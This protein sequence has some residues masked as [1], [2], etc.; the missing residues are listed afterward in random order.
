MNFESRIDADPF[1]GTNPLL[2]D[3]GQGRSKRRLIIAGVVLLLIMAAI[4][5]MVHRAGAGAGAEADKKDQ[6][7]VVSVIT[8]GRATIEGTISA[9]GT[10]AARRELPVGIAGEG[11]QVV[12][13]LV[14]PGQWVRAGQVMAVIDRSVQVQQ[15]SSQAAQVS[16]ARANADLA[17]AN[18]DRALKLV[19][20]GFVSKADVDRLRA[21]RDAAFAQVRVAGAQLGVL[22]A[23]SRRL[24]VV[25]PAAGLVLERKVEPGQIVSGGSGLLFRLAKGG[26]MELKAA[27]GQS[28]LAQIAPGV[29]AKVTPVGSTNVYTGQVWQKAPVIDPVSRQG[30]ARIALAYAPDLP[31]GGFASAEIKSGTVVAPMLPESAILSDAKGSYVYVVDKDNKVRR[32]PVTTGLITNSGTAVVAGLDGTERVVLRSG[33]FLNEGDPIKPKFDKP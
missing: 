28:D 8:P 3:E 11:G 22:N 5:F 2:E 25:A 31:P 24:N 32:R 17:Q 12:S 20:K 30:F 21:T 27:L 10:L 18:L 14:E 23:Q 29:T 9:T 6:A 13:V 15:Q 26:E 19:D 4:W 33:A 7:P 16:V 1:T